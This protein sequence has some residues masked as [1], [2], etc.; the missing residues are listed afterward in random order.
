[1]PSHY[2]LSKY[3]YL[4]TREITLQDYPFYSLIAAA[5]RQADTDNLELLTVAFPGV[6]DSFKV[7]YNTPMDWN[8][9]RHPEETTR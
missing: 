7:W 9:L 4:V 3:D 2:R 6:V 1:M 5:I 8:N